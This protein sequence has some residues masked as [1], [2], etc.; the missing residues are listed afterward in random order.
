MA[1]IDELKERWER[2]LHEMADAEDRVE[3][4]SVELYHLDI[5]LSSL[6][7][8]LEAPAQPHGE[9]RDAPGAEEEETP[10]YGDDLAY[11]DGNDARISNMPI[12]CN[13]YDG[14]EAEYWNNGWNDADAIIKMNAPTDSGEHDRTST[15][16]ADPLL[17][18]FENDHIVE[19]A[20]LIDAQTCEEVDP[21]CPWKVEPETPEGFT[22]WEGTS[23]NPTGVPED[24]DSDTTV[25]V[26][27]R[28]GD[29][30]F[31]LTGALAGALD[32]FHRAT[33]SHCDIIAYRIIT[34]EAE[35]EPEGYAPVVDALG[36][37]YDAGFDDGEPN[38]IDAAVEKGAITQDEAEPV[39]DATELAQV[40]I[41]KVPPTAEVIKDQN[42]RAKFALFGG[43]TH[44]V[45]EPATT[46]ADFWARA[47][48]PKKKEQA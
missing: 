42:G 43:Q 39:L 8:K 27:Y 48:F 32:W 40:T 37:T 1:L 35:P 45:V 26:L 23:L 17:S 15:A 5:A 31:K 36:G 6:T 22:K 12:E 14:K 25:D 10:V 13:P 38:P 3:Q 4:L 33:A 21:R 41:D 24:L 47:L 29:R 28:N 46:E 16:P 9:L 18:A 11:G 20:P 30:P 19:R 7:K 44:E 2:K 34:P